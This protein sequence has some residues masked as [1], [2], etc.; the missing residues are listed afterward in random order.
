MSENLT[1][2][3]ERVD[4]VPLLLAQIERMGVPSLL[5]S[6][7][8]VHGNRQGL[9]LG[10][11]STIWLAH[12]LS[13]AD[14]RLN[15]VRPW[16][17]T[18]HETLHA[19]VPAPL[20][21]TDLTDD[22]LADVLRALSDDTHWAAFEGALNAHTLRVYDLRASTVR[23]DS[24]TASG[25]WSV[26]DEGLFQFGHSKDHRPDLPQVKVMLATLDPLGMPLAVDVVAGQSADDPLYLPVIARVRASL[27]QTGLLYVGDCKLAALLTRAQVQAGGDYYLCPLPSSQVAADWLAPWLEQGLADPAT[28]TAVMR[29]G[30]DGQPTKLAEG[31]EQ[32]VTLTTLV[33]GQAVTWTERRM[34]VR[35]LAQAHAQQ[36]ALQ[37]RVQHALASLADLTIRRRGKARLPDLAALE[38]AAAAVLARY[39]VADLI[40]V[41]CTSRP[42]ERTVRGYRGQGA[43]LVVEQ[44]LRLSAV[45]DEQAIA[46]ASARL[47][48]R[49]YVTNQGAEQL[50][51]AQAVLAYRDEYLVERSLGRLK[52]QPLSLSPFYLTRDDHA[53][54]LIRLL[55]IGVRVLTLV[56]FVVRRRL[57]QNG[58]AVAGLY[59]GNP[60][61]TT[62][63]PTAERLL[64]AFGN[65]T[66]TIVQLPGQLIRHLTPLSA[67]QQQLLALLDLDEDVYSRL[68]T[69]SAQPP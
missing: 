64:E 35:S 67:L 1:I 48:W 45:A 40:A 46:A 16:A 66:L 11:V 50:S 26:T 33:D 14:H 61:R 9:S 69:H 13:R 8:P 6:H 17:E 34:L 2:Q 51:L 24:T 54:G 29:S 7:F 4:D 21:P 62:T 65:L 3:T 30:P 58:T 53:T 38:Q 36:T 20:R 12:I 15:Q 57:E 10:W 55:T 32:A 59:V 52:G 5:D 63:R 37:Q 47:G 41:T 44:D 39:Q 31:C 42:R 18:L 56:E 22:R 68:G 19:S 27:G 25:Y 23:V 43:R 28:L 60:T 49:V